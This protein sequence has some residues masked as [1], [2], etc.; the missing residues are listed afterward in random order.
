MAG[1][2]SG[3]GTYAQSSAVLW[4][5]DGSTYTQFYELNTKAF[6]PARNNVTVS[7]GLSDKKFDTAYLSSATVVGSDRRSKTNI[8]ALD[9]KAVSFVNALHPVSYKLAV[10]KTEILETD[11]NGDPVRVEEHPGARTHWGFI[12]QEVKE[13]MTQAGIEDAAAWTLADKDDPDSMQSLR[14]EE[15]IAPLVKAVQVLAAKVEALE[16]K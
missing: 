9:D 8:D 1:D 10:G 12:A 2:T 15:L 4:L 13:A 3:S 16:G 7:L 6:M 11:Q 5:Q 14:Y